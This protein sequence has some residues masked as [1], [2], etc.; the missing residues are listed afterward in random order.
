MHAPLP[1]VGVAFARAHGV[2][3]APQCDSVVRVCS[4]PFGWVVSQLPQPPL[5]DITRHEPLGQ[6]CVAVFGRAH[7]FVHDPQLVG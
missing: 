7:T 3:H 1:H 2:A 6:E 4:Q 5:Q